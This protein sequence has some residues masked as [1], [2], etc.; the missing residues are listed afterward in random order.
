MP[1]KIKSSSL[2]S[3][4]ALDYY[5]KKVIF[6]KGGVSFFIAYRHFNTTTRKNQKLNKNNVKLL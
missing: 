5:L 2:S 4:K 6:F 3:G 1:K